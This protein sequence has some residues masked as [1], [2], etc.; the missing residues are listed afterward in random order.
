MET[1]GA[2]GY[3]RRVASRKVRE[4]LAAGNKSRALNSLNSGEQE[5]KPKER[6]DMP[7]CAAEPEEDVRI[8]C[9]ADHRLNGEY[10]VCEKSGGSTT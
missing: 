3:E 9:P 1:Q 5:A 6:P 4:E 8:L 7:S 10:K 2:C